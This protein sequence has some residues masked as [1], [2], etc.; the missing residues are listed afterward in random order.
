MSKLS[1]LFAGCAMLVLLCASSFLVF[2]DNGRLNPT[3]IN[4]NVMLCPGEQ[5]TLSTQE[6]DTYQWHKDGNPIPG[7][8]NQTHVVSYYAD[9]GSSFTVFVTQGGQSA[10]SPS[11]LV[12][13]WVFLPL[14]VSSY[15]QGYWYNPLTGWELCEYHE[16][17]FQVMMPYN[18]NIQWYRDNIPIPGATSAIY[19][20]EQTGVHTVRGSPAT[21][22]NYVQYSVPLP[23]TVHVPPQ[24][25]I[26]EQSDTLFTSVF[27]GQWYAGDN[28]IPGETGEFL[29]PP[30][31]GWYSFEFTDGNGCKK[32]SEPYYYEWNPVG[33]H[34]VWEDFKPSLSVRGNML[35]VNHGSAFDFEIY[36]VAGSLLK[37]GQR[38][39]NSID[40]SSLQPGLYLIRISGNDGIFVLRFIR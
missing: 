34:K 17:I 40:I 22:P 12:D 8:T 9:A 1:T 24:P 32:M 14:T 38:A 19:E 13:G 6:Y 25:V 21:C 28:P 20:V 2:A 7:A 35:F 4:G 31:D 23:V 33:I 11:I 29:V 39:E 30:S 36:S 5:E 26:T 3:I 15:G 27:P 18:T 37:K 10:M 16:L